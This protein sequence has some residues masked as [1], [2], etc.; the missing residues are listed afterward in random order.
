MVR[1][2]ALDELTL[3]DLWHELS[4]EPDEF[5]ADARQKQLRLAKTLIRERSRKR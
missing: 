4:P 1:V 2:K 3:G 5:W